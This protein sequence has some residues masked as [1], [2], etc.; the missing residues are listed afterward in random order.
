MSRAFWSVGSVLAAIASLVAVPAAVAAPAFS[1]GSLPEAAVTGAGYTPTVG[2]TL[3][4]R[5]DGRVALAFDTTL[6]CGHAVTLVRTARVVAW[7]GATL[8]AAG[9]SRSPFGGRRARYSWALQAH[10]DGQVATGSVQIAARR[11]GRLCRGRAPRTFVARLGTAPAG[12]PSLPAAGAVYYGGGP[13]LVAGRGPGSTVLRVSPDGRRVAARWFAAARCGRRGRERLTNL[14]PPTRIGADGAFAR[15]ERFAV[16][17]AD[18]TI[19]YRVS[20]RGRFTGATAAG[21]LRLRATALTRRTGRV[22]ARCDT[23][24]RSWSAWSDGEPPP[25]APGPAPTPPDPPPP[26]TSPDPT[27][28]PTPV[29][30]SWSFDMDG[31]PGEYI[32]QGEAWHHGSAYGEPI[33]L[34]VFSAGN[35][36]QFAIQTRDGDSWTGSYSTGD[37][38]PLQVGTYTTNGG[39]GSASQ[40]YGGHGRG[41]GRFTGTFTVTALAY[42]PNGALRTF[43][44]N[45]EAHCEGLAEALRGGFAF[46]AA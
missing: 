44:V 13:R 5:A 20:F 29:V 38:S 3:A 19:R 42:D 6:R 9:V 43:N 25:A 2:V 34:D 23:R 1:G 30:G 16:R 46:Q 41:C 32:S 14:T 11:R 15:R 40:G 24:R 28:R 31:D 8:S 39:P 35:I 37:G 36:I 18:A 33:K 7:D 12:A 45:F 22:I 10:A 26:P 21:S 27:F 17:Y 4:P